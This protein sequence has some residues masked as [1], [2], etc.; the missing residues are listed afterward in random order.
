MTDRVYLY[1]STLRDG[2]QARGVD[3]TVA[4]KRAIALELD[5]FGID[6]VE[7]GWPGANPRDDAFFAEPPA[8]KQ[9]RLTAFGMTRR[10]GRSVSNDPGLAALLEANTGSICLVGK[11]WDFHIEKA[12]EITLEE[13]RRMIAES[14]THLA[15]KK[16][17]VLFDAEHFFDGYKHNPKVALDMAKA[18]YEAG[19]RW[20]VLCDTNGG[21]LPHEIA[22][23]VAKVAKHI[24]S[25]HLGIHCHNDTEN[26]VANSLAAVQAGARQVQGTINGIGERC[27]NANLISII[28]TLM[29]KLGFKTGVSAKKLQQITELSRFVD[30]RLNR[31]P[32][33]H[34]PYVG[35]A[36]FAH[37]GGLHVSAMAKDTASYEHIKPE[38]VGNER[39]ILVSDKAGRSNIASR[40]TQLGLKAEAKSEHI[41]ELVALV[42]ERE[43]Q[44]YAY[45]GADA[46]FELLARRVL[47][48]VPE[49]FDLLTFRVTSERRVNAKGA[50][51]TLSEAVIKLVA[52]RKKV[53]T[54]GEGNGPVDALDAALRKALSRQ[55]PVLKTMRLTDY[56]VRIL[57]PQEGTKATTRVMIESRDQDGLCWTTIGV[58][59]NVI[60]ASYNA[61]NDAI[62][63][64]LLKQSSSR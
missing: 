11:A 46:S 39:T 44:G 19:A 64:R 50:L 52:G 14:I 32:N 25:T 30:D 31:A 53:M 56:K 47:G 48:E 33:P 16:R 54:V 8:L 5:A 4:D 24:P 22:D 15:K 17:E 40:L 59:P 6:Y 55:Y 3:F 62:T 18:A 28:P 7:G 49:Y 2:A 10:A 41:D 1:D 57:T 26:A 51:V 60:D 20:V 42:K 23:I 58:S 29:L 35:S 9:T 34:A 45:E 61:L 27:G 37:K 43:T 12:L 13:N 21:S 38:Q 36:A 63:Y